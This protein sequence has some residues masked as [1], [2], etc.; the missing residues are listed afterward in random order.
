[1]L[2]LVPVSLARW[3]SLVH[4]AGGRSLLFVADVDTLF[5]DA[6]LV[7]IVLL[8]YRSQID[9]NGSVAYLVFTIGLASASGLLLAFVVTN[10]GAMLRLR[11]LSGVPIWMATLGLAS[12]RPILTLR[13][14]PPSLS[15]STSRS[16]NSNIT[17]VH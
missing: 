10:L 3:L 5:F 16:T 14:I 4:I 17:A 15:E 12:Y 6:T 7:L 8:V 1:M 2:L 9:D 11:L 13:G